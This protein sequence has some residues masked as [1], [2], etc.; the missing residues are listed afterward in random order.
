MLLSDEFLPEFVSCANWVELDAA[1]A[2]SILFT[3]SFRSKTC[4]QQLSLAPALGPR[5][6]KINCN[7]S[8]YDK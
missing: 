6:R 2:V 8:Y 7:F 3:H 1:A 4:S 5:K